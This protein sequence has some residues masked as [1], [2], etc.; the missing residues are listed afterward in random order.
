MPNGRGF[1]TTMETHVKVMKEKEEWPFI[2]F[3]AGRHLPHQLWLQKPVL[4][5]M[6]L[7]LHVRG[8][9]HK[10]LWAK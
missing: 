1:E 3:R 7:L 2:H 8:S 9:R 10:V 5:R 6:Y 4:S